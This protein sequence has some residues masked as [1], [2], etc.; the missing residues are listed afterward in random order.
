MSIILVSNKI[1]PIALMQNPYN[2]AQ[3]A[4]PN[5]LSFLRKSTINELTKMVNRLIAIRLI[6][7]VNLSLGRGYNRSLSY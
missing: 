2:A 5:G 6:F 7:I 4:H 3:K 1:R